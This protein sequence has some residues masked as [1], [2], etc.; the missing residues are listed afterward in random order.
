MAQSV[1]HV[2]HP[3]E[4]TL[5]IT[6]ELLF[7]NKGGERQNTLPYTFSLHATAADHVSF[8]AWAGD[9]VEQL[10]FLLLSVTLL[11]P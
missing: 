6:G 8:T 4:S 1:L 3:S 10:F 11:L 2:H 5:V 9:E 7:E